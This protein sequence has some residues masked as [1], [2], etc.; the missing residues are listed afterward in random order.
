MDIEL[1]NLLFDK[2]H[3]RDAIRCISNIDDKDVVECIMKLRK[4]H[5]EYWRK[6]MELMDKEGREE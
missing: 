2:A 5:D 4:I 3:I 1:M 6:A